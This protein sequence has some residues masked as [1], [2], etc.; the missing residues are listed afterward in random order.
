VLDAATEDEIAT[1]VRAGGPGVADPSGLL[2]L[3]IFT[4]ARRIRQQLP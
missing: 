1:W 3:R 2:D 4:P